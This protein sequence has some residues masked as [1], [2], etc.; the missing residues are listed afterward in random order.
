MAYRFPPIAIDDA[1]NGNIPPQA[2]ANGAQV[3]AGP[4]LFGGA[5]Y[6]V[7]QTG[8]FPVLSCDVFTSTDNGLTWSGLDLGGSANNTGN[9]GC[10]F[11]G[12]HTIRIAWS[13]VFAPAAKGLLQMEDFDLV[14]GT[15]GGAFATGGP[16]SLY[17]YAC[18][19]LGNGNTLVI[20][21]EDNFV[22]ANPLRNG[23][24]WSGS[25]S[26]AFDLNTKVAIALGPT[27]GIDD[28]FNY[29]MNAAKT[30]MH[31]TFF[32]NDVSA[33]AFLCY[34]AVNQDGTL[35]PV[36]TFAN[37]GD[38]FGSGP[39]ADTI[40]LAG[41]NVIIFFSQEFVGFQ[42]VW[43]GTPISAPVW[44]ETLQIDPDSLLDPTITG[45]DPGIPLL[46][47]SILY[48]AYTIQTDPGNQKNRIRLLQTSNLSNPALGWTG[49][50]IFNGATNGGPGW[51]QTD[52]LSPQAVIDLNGNPSVL[53][54]SDA[55]SGSGFPIR[56]WLQF[57]TGS[58]VISGT[59][60]SGTVGIGYSF[61]F[62]ATGG[63]PPYAWSV[64]AGGLPPGLVLSPSG[65]CITGTPSAAGSFPV[66]VTVTDSVSGTAFT[67]PVILIIASAL[68][69]LVIQ[70][71]GYK[72][73]PD[74]P[75]ADPVQ[76]KPIPKPDWWK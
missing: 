35:G 68:P 33:N 37:A 32:V 1:S 10:S 21:S 27:N 39:P 45:N 26:A 25:W 58:P 56:Y 70:L 44:T 9:F 4:F 19:F 75:C 14:A 48:L 29:V 22:S 7:L 76:V 15:W 6:V 28:V 2:M 36:H 53:V 24:I 66:T 54:S 20:Y 41:D 42:S 49:A 17:V 30:V 74:S 65:G 71:I 31:C 52:L 55:V 23:A 73:F 12:I 61:C 62:T 13:G 38:S 57:L 46:A 72:L 50:T 69:S 8:T 64:T 11:D 51:I 43:V 40:G 34:Q 47:G 63:T 16:E 59:P 18:E 5:L 60:P 3:Y 67:A